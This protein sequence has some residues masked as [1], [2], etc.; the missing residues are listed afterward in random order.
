MDRKK[1]QNVCKHALVLTVHCV[2][3]EPIMMAQE[4]IIRN[5]HYRRHETSSV[6]SP[7]HFWFVGAQGGDIFSTP[8]VFAH[9]FIFFMY[10][11][12]I[13][14]FLV[15]HDYPCISQTDAYV[16]FSPCT[17]EK[18]SASTSYQWSA[19]KS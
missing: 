8:N 2:Q 11:I 1:K 3:L 19:S 7:A 14:F 6:D 4:L 12:W 16:I 15:V 18:W 13:F 9:S 5:R 17:T 10:F